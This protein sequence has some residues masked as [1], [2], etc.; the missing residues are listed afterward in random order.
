MFRGNVLCFHV[1]HL[2][3][4]RDVC[5]HLS[6]I[7]GLIGR[8]EFSKSTGEGCHMMQ[9]ARA[10]VTGSVNFHSSR[11]VVPRHLKVK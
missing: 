4:L 10:L 2:L 8:V 9:T 3:S 5:L 11:E 6:I 7:V 1:C